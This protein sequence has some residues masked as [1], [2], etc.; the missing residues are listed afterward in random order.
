MLE[1]GQIQLAAQ[2]QHPVYLVMQVPGHQFWELQTPQTA[3]YAR[4]VHGPTLL[5]R[6]PQ[7]Y[8]II[9]SLEF[10]RLLAPLHVLRAMQV[11]GRQLPPHRCQASV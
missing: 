1:L 5:E 2:D 7:W 11:H 6:R 4:L 10:G 8:A 9:A 3:F